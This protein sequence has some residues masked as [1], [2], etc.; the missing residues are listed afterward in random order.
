MAR[1][2]F[3]EKEL[4]KAWALVTRSIEHTDEELTLLGHEEQCIALLGRELRAW[5]SRQ[6]VSEE[7]RK[8]EQE[9]EVRD[10]AR[11]EYWGVRLSLGGPFPSEDLVNAVVV[12]VLQAVE[13]EDLKPYAE[14]GAKILKGNA[15]GGKRSAELLK[16]KA[17]KRHKE[18]L[19][20]ARAMLAAGKPRLGLAGRLK[21]KFGLSKRPINV[22][23]KENGL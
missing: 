1:A 7:S 21:H 15:K 12:A 20:A 2:G 8:F 19:D 14:R 3:T 11:Q 23:L 17:K 6:P 13:K 4:Y 9:L 10:R 5:R 22:I 18:G 16:G